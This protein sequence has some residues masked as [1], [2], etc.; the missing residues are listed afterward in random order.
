MYIGIIFKNFSDFSE[1]VT[2]IYNQLANIMLN[3]WLNYLAKYYKLLYM[4][5]Q[6]L[7]T[8]NIK[9]LRLKNG[10]TQEQ[11]AEKIGI[12]INGVSNI[13]R[14]RYQPTAKM[15]DK[16]CSAFN[17]TPAELLVTNTSACE[18]LVISINTLI[19]NC[20][21]KQLKQIRDIILILLRKK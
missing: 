18:D 21:V 7:I 5:Y 10:L 1:I 19:S 16:I 17:I 13:E 2:K 15:I 6:K 20:S 11:F 4:N 9:N 8:S 12:T 14:N 3:C